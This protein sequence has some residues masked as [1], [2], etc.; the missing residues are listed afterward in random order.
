MA[1]VWF[2][3]LSIPVSVLISSTLSSSSPTSVET[4]SL[5]DS[6]VCSPALSCTDGSRSRF[7]SSCSSTMYVRGL[8]EWLEVPVASMALRPCQLWS[9][10]SRK[11]EMEGVEGS[12]SR[13]PK[14]SFSV[15]FRLGGRSREESILL[16]SHLWWPSIWPDR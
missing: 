3:N 5:L 6:L 9:T 12:Q 10:V 1:N 7:P 13:F 14:A 2:T 15:A 8:K 16:H 4:D 11:E